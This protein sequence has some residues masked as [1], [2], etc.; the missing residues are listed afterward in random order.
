MALQT[1]FLEIYIAIL[2]INGG[3]FMVDSLVDTPLKTPFDTT[4]NV[5]S[6]TPPNL[7][8]S[9]TNTGTLTGNFTTLDSLTNATI[10]GAGGAGVN[11][12]D[13]L[14][15]PITLLYTFVQLITGGFIWETLA[16]FGLP[17]AMTFVLQGIIGL[18]L[19]ITIVYYLTGR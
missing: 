11:P 8:N 7:F 17:S 9:T 2:C 5:T 18:M 3:I 16:I 13:S 10:G 14:L 6:S 1:H 4:G 19:A 12:I 15:Y